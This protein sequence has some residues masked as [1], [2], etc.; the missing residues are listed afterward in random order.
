MFF[1]FR[2]LEEVEAQLE[3]RQAKVDEFIVNTQRKKAELEESLATISSANKRATYVS[4]LWLR[5]SH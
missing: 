5:F 1:A 3:A 2:Q 4:W